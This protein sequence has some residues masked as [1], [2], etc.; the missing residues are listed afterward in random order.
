MMTFALVLLAA[1]STG[2]GGEESPTT[3]VTASPDTTVGTTST[4]TAGEGPTTTTV[5]TDPLPTGAALLINYGDS[6]SIRTPDGDNLSLVGDF[7]VPLGRAYDD[8]NGGIVL[9]YAAST[10][11]L[12]ESILHLRA[13]SG[14]P[15][16]LVTAADGHQ[17]RLLDVGDYNGRLYAMYLDRAGD[18]TQT[19]DLIGLDGG[20]PITLGEGR[21]ILNGSLGEDHYSYTQ[22]MVGC[23]IG[24]IFDTSGAETA[25]WA[26]PDGAAGLTLGEGSA[27]WL[28]PDGI[29][30]AD[31]DGT[32]IEAPW[33]PEDR[34]TTELFDFDDSVAVTRASNTA[35]RF[36]AGDGSATRFETSRRIRSVTILRAPIQL[37]GTASLGG[38]RAPNGQCSAS[39]FPAVPTPVDGL[40]LASTE[41]RSAIVAAAHDCEFDALEALAGGTLTVPGSSDLSRYWIEREQSRFDD[42]AVMVRV[43]D[44]S[45]TQLTDAAGNRT[46]VWPAAA[47]ADVPSESEW[48]ELGAIYNEEDI[49][50]MRRAGSYGGVVITISSDGEWLTAGILDR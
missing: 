9:Q 46:F 37:T 18:G 12:D 6:L 20:A 22:Q 42:L 23:R 47:A 41:T 4:S 32:S 45:Y 24:V 39:G 16:K 15:L 26:C 27:A 44:L 8:L 28:G 43:L 33:E 30:L 17:L 50:Q 31:I 13:N 21:S 25:R 40:T 19:I 49:E 1:C 10:T 2:S 35:F 36:L 11:N 14:E 29:E 38:L 3:T 7:E 5:A 48:R 34:G